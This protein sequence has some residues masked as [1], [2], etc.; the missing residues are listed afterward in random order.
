MS[1][2]LL[3]RHGQAS[4][5]SADYDRLSELGWRQ[6]TELG[7][8][9][10]RLGLVPDRVCVGPCRRQ[11]ET[12]EAVAAAFTAGRRPWPEPEPL[13][14]LD[15]HDGYMVFTRSL[16]ALAESDTEAR[17]AL[18]LVDQPLDEDM[19]LYYRVYRR[20]TRSW[21]RGELDLPAGEPELEDWPVFRRRA[22]S[23]LSELVDGDGSGRTVVAF[24][25]AGPVAVAVGRALGLDDETVLSLSWAVRN[26]SVSEF[27]F[28]GERFSLHSFNSQL[29]LAEPG[30]ESWV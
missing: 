5:G 22:E 25:S 2:L 16:P 9:W 14:E 7:R 19:R 28:S 11:L 3:V 26:C 23:A 15:E 13:P 24:T 12:A 27:L 30:L 10:A 21:A 17:T 4:A 29:H 6:A 1:R 18:E 20:A 8:H